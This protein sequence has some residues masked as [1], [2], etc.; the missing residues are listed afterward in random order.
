MRCQMSP[1]PK[2]VSHI[3]TYLNTPF[4]HITKLSNVKRNSYGNVSRS[5]SIKYLCRFKHLTSLTWAWTYCPSSQFEL[6]HVTE[7]SWHSISRLKMTDIT[8]GARHTYLILLSVT[9]CDRI[10]IRTFR[11]TTLALMSN[12]F[13]LNQPNDFRHAPWPCLD[14]VCSPP[15]RPESLMYGKAAFLVLSWP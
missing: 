5:A 15:N 11:S 1:F 4:V 10:S 6:C 2:R 8:C 9:F 14:F 7:W 13:R 3:P 12:L